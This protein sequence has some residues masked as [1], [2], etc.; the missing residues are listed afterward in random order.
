MS[1]EEIN[2]AIAEACPQLFEVHEGW[3]ASTN[4]YVPYLTRRGEGITGAAID[5]L[6]DL[7][8]MHEA[9]MS[10]N[11]TQRAKYRSELADTCRPDGAEP[12]SIDDLLE[13]IDATAR[14][15]AEAFLRAMNLWKGQ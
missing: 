15:R 12:D 11:Q 14:Q 7:N 2:Q 3:N 5:P 13:A 1:D 10:L 8:A 9:V 4:K 6:S